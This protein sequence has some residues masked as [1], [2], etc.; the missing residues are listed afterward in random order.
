MNARG[1]LTELV[2]QTVYTVS[3]RRPNRILEVD[4]DA[5]VVGTEK[6]PGGEQVPIA[7]VQEAM[8]QL[9]TT[10]ELAVSVKVI[11][12]RSAFVGAVLSSLPGVEIEREP[13][14]LVLRR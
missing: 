14:K 9:S 2:G 4:G 5:V 10:G 1:L 11:G 13:T 7:M 6:T 3:Q 8:D 12:Y